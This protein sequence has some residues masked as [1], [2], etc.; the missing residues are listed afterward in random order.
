[1][2]QLPD[3]DVL[4]LPAGWR[5]HVPARRGRP[6][7]AP[8]PV[9]PGAPGALADRIAGL[10]PLLD[11]WL[12][13]KHDARSAAELARHLDTAPDPV[14]A[15]A[16]LHLVE[17]S[18]RKAIDPAARLR[19]LDAWVAEHGLGFAAVAVMESATVYNWTYSTGDAAIG[20]SGLST[21]L[22]WEEPEGWRKAQAAV[23]RIRALLAAASEQDYR[24]AVAVMAAHRTD[25]QRRIGS[26]LLMP[27]EA[28][29]VAEAVPLVTGYFE[30]RRADDWMFWAIAADPRDWELTLHRGVDGK[31]VDER[32]L[33][34]LL[35]GVGTLALPALARVLEYSFA[36]LSKPRRAALLTA[37]G[38]LPDDE[39]TALLVAH[40]HLPGAIT[41]ARETAERF[42]RRTLRAVAARA[43]DPEARSD[44]EGL[45]RASPALEAALADA[46]EPVRAAVAA[47]FDTDGRVPEAEPGSLPPLLADPPW[48]RKRRRE[49][50]PV[51]EGLAP[52]SAT[53]LV[54][55]GP[56]EAREW[57]ALRE[58]NPYTTY[59]E[60]E[61]R[62]RLARLEEH[63]TC[64]GMDTFL[65]WARMEDAEP[66]LD[67]WDG[68]SSHPYDVTL[69]RIL[70][71]FGAR[72]A[73]RVV[74]LVKGRNA[75]AE[76]LIP[77]ESLDAA[78]IAAD[79]LARSRA[80]A[81]AATRWFARHAAAAPHLL[82][83]D[84]LGSDADLRRAA[85]VGLRHCITEWGAEPVAAAAK[86]YGEEAAAAIGALIDADP[87]DPLDA[88]I[89]KPG[90]WAAPEMLPQLLLEGR[91]SALPAASVGHLLTVL[92]LDTPERPY[93]GVGVV[94]EA[95]DPDSLAAFSRALFDLWAAAGSPS[96]DAWAFTQLAHFADDGTVAHLAE[97][98]RRWPGEGQHK[99][100]VEGLRVLGAIGSE[101]SLRALHAI[102]RKVRFKALKQEAGR[103]VEAVAARLGLSADQLAD[104]LVPRF[105]LDDATGLVL[106]YGPRRFAIGFD[107]RLQPFVTD[108]D[109]RP[110]K[111]LPKPGATDDDAL[112]DPAYR[113][114]GE[115][116]RELRATAK[117]QVARLERAMAVQR[118]WTTA[119]FGDFFTGHP[120]MRHL[121]R[122]LVWEAETAHG[123][124]HFRIAEDGTFTDA[125]DDVYAPPA[126]AAIRL[127]HPASLGERL[128]DWSELFADYEVLQPFRQLD[129]PVYAFTAEEAATGRLDR[130]TGTTF[131]VARIYPLAHAGWRRAAETNA[132]WLSPGLHFPL[133][134]GGFVM[135]VLDPGVDGYLGRVDTDQPDQTVR[136]VH[137]APTADYDAAPEGGR[138]DA[139]DP[140]TASE[141]LHALA[142]ATGG[143]ARP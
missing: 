30:E 70:G 56:D 135:L 37:I 67:R 103:Q 59:S 3:E 128:A 24:E 134:A 58:D 51:F 20:E 143:A 122:R 142:K 111:T 60:R 114:F 34:V 39:A 61:V 22:E 100:A 139:V 130:F 26:A 63:G 9:D 49:D 18:G 54:W 55:G 141:V 64:E 74:R 11:R 73:D 106:D 19:H 48:K 25:P 126:E 32:S 77:V 23:V 4:I 87:L 85:T 29:W 14:G 109:G 28:A 5:R 101:T 46:E 89:P 113:R 68:D 7:A 140:V 98:V 93:P 8:A 2:T 66:L 72:A 35:D 120:L 62:S 17:V 95:C 38:L 44:L 71:R 118:S 119:Q 10:R 81:P 137:F 12:T 76:V 86:A 117:E 138:L 112:A 79:W 104:R 41:A 97:L 110:L 27:A 132:L 102:A 16:L 88:K 108:E 94:A 21:Y 80:S 105:G 47:L 92:A 69:Q 84:A 50:R 31:H 15:A 82:V 65:G 53:R 121:A 91:R 52:E 1:M 99:R 13:E 75:L 43:A 36:G 57:A 40:L 115:L 45:V 42:P 33:A 131:P 107:E 6:A 83:P 136:S 127:A 116:K 124:A 96:K 133:P 78:R 125:A 129:R 123:K 90:A